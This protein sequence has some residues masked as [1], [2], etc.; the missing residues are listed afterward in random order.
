[1]TEIGSIFFDAKLDDSGLVAAV[2]RA[3]RRASQ[4]AEV[5]FTADADFADLGVK[6]KAAARSAG[7]RVEF[8]AHL[9]S[10]GFR[11]DTRG[12]FGHLD[13]GDLPDFGGASDALRTFGNQ[14]QRTAQKASLF[15]KV[16]ASS[17]IAMVAFVQVAAQ[18]IPVVVGLAGAVVAL[19]SAVAFA[20]G[21]AL[22]GIATGL[23]AIGLAAVTVKVGM[24]GL[25]DAF[26][27]VAKAQEE[28]ARTGKISEE[29]LKA[30][31][32]A[33]AGLAPSARRFV[34]AVVSIQKAWQGV[35]KAV[36][37]RL[38]AG[39]GSEIR[40]TAT[41]VLPVL[42]RGLTGI[43][44]VLNDG[45]KSFLQWARS[46]K[47]T[48]A[49]S[50]ILSG[51]KG[52]LGPLVQ[53]V[54]AF[55]QG[56][57]TL[58]QGSLPFGQKLATA[59]SD[60]AQ[61]FSDWAGKF[62]KTGGL[63]D[64]LD[65]A[66]KAGSTL[67][68][69]LQNIGSI[70]GS[71]FGGGEKTGQGFLTSIEEITGRFDDF[72]KS[73]EGQEKIKTFFDDA[74][75]AVDTLKGVILVAGPALS[76]FFQGLKA[77]QPQIDNFLSALGK[78]A[79]PIRV[80][81]QVFGALT[82]PLSVVTTL[83]A[84][85]VNFLSGVDWAGIGAAISGGFT[86]AFTTLQQRL[87]EAKAGIEGFLGQVG[88]F[89]ASI[90]AA[91]GGFFTMIGT[92][93]STGFSEALA[94]LQQRLTEAGAGISGFVT[95]IPGFFAGLATRIVTAAG[96]LLGSFTLWVAGVVGVVVSVASQVASAF[97]GL[98]RIIA[99]AG[100]LI[101]SFTGWVSGLAG[102]AA[103]TAANIVAAFAG[104]AG[105]IIARGREPA[106]GVQRLGLRADRGGPTRS[107]RDRQRLL[108][109]RR[110]DRRRDRD[111]G[112]EDQP[113]RHPRHRLSVRRRWGRH[114]PD[115]GPDRRSRAGGRRPVA[116]QPAPRLRR[117]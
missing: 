42:Q 48:K 37:G 92:A 1:M 109:S 89:F 112:P 58:F 23:G 115:P 117:R 24:S 114:L 59:I 104:L 13:P 31:K 61:A 46:A 12:L 62:V 28:Q 98:G 85:L 84:T 8:E 64:F 110:A 77:N 32:Q 95:S 9:D 29:T 105:K 57:L 39:L 65:K 96:D 19:A 106:G 16:F 3:A 6:A 35:A 40:K 38:F 116:P 30:Q 36:Q 97:A 74:V 21:G 113:A 78:F 63:T 99:G 4:Q 5:T 17:A 100:S 26:K 67:W 71:V 56:L 79:G 20:A 25:G 33:L 80:I 83:I 72:L 88:G 90:G 66:W 51:I 81:G 34:L 55:G 49:I 108:R 22:A 93:V 82:M 11:H 111:G 44:D 50:G 102:V 2:Q 69:I 94:T 10:K 91:I 87:G 107:E 68:G 76:G 41:A 70:I 14:A 54:G 75:K 86:E 47:G 101:A 103:R 15:E 27:A 60:I 18:A 45:A 7:Q 52:I 73:A 53:A 43:A